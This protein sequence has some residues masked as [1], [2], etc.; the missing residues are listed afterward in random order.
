MLR[1][2]DWPPL[3]TRSTRFGNGV[4]SRS[5]NATDPSEEPSSTTIIS[6]GGRV[7]AAALPIE[8]AR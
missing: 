6:N 5:A 7:W 1:A 8:A 3:A 4:S 2:R